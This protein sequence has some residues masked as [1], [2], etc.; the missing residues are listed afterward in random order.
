M[1]VSLMV[2]RTGEA[3]ITVT[4]YWRRVESRA[5]QRVGDAAWIVSGIPLGHL[6]TPTAITTNDNTSNSGSNNKDAAAATAT[7]DDV[8]DSAKSTVENGGMVTIQIGHLSTVSQS[9][10]AAA[11]SGRPGYQLAPQ[12]HQAHAPCGPPCRCPKSAKQTLIRKIC[13]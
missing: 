2:K 13:N 7:K 3:P 1:V 5:Q 10:L 11:A 6:P 9:V 8:A 4:R 12:I